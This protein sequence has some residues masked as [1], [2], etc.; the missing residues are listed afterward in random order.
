MDLLTVDDR[1]IV[2]A[3]LGRVPR[4]RF[5]IARRCSYGHPQVLRVYPVLN[6]K[7]FP[8]LYWLTCPHLELLIDRI[9]ASGEVGRLEAALTEDATLR[10][11]LE[12]AH[13]AYIEQRSR[14]LDPEDREQLI[15]SGRIGALS[16]R[17]IG[18][19]SDRRFIKCLHL[20]VAHE[21]GDANPI[22]RRVLERLDAIECPESGVICS[23]F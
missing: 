8:T 17:G 16:A 6:G 21:L 23:T 20:H 18:G 3:Q 11:E 15:S 1:R 22:G 19:I 13:D 12:A 2:E 9:E 5:D 10:R 4:G 7:P 14:L